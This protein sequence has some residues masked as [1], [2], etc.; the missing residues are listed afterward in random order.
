[1]SFCIRS[2]GRQAQSENSYCALAWSKSRFLSYYV[3]QDVDH[4]THGDIAWKCSER[5]PRHHGP[6]ESTPPEVHKL[7]QRKNDAHDGDWQALAFLAEKEEEQSKEHTLILCHIQLRL[8][9]V[10]KFRF[11]V[12]RL[13]TDRI[14]PSTCLPR[15][16]AK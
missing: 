9:C 7:G 5:R 12:L 6:R 8:A 4:D 13:R 2:T 16:S 3:V 15:S 1:M 14:I 11:C 10:L